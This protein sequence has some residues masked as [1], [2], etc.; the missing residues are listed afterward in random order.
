MTVD[1]LQAFLFMMEKILHTYKRVY[2]VWRDNLDDL[3]TW[4]TGHLSKHVACY[5]SRKVLI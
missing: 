5:M 1:Y 4:D 3:G 2:L